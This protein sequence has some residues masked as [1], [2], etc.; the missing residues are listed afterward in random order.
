M[1]FVVLMT[2]EEVDGDES[3]A[4]AEETAE[5]MGPTI[6]EMRVGRRMFTEPYSY[7]YLCVDM[8]CGWCK[9]TMAV[10][11]LIYTLVLT[12]NLM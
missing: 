4:G 8:S 9:R 12:C 3:V 10:G 5:I 1:I 7:C 2:G 11:V 6:R